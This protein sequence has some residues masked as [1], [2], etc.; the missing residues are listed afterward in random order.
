[1]PLRVVVAAPVS[2]LHCFSSLSI[3]ARSSLIRAS[4]SSRRAAETAASASVCAARTN[5]ARHRIVRR[6]G[7]AA[8]CVR[9]QPPVDSV[10]L[11][12]TASW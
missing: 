2:R 3:R 10:V 6:V 1:M 4:M 7:I 5:C 8:L 11:A 9:G 12:T